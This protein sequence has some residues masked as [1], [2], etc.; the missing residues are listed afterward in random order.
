VDVEVLPVRLE[1]T[2]P[3][4]ACQGEG[5]IGAPG[6]PNPPEN[7]RAEIVPGDGPIAGQIILLTWD[8]NATDDICYTIEWT[9]PAPLAG[10]VRLDPS[11]CLCRPLSSKTF[12]RRGHILL[13]HQLWQ[14]AGR[15]SYS[16]EAC[17][18]CEAEPV[19]T[20]PTLPPHLSPETSPTPSPTPTPSPRPPSG[21][22]RGEGPTRAE[23]LPTTRRVPRDAFIGRRCVRGFIVRLQWKTTPTTSNAAIIGSG[24]G[25]LGVPQVEAPSVQ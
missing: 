7:L 10:A 17:V 2:P 11:A 12:L 16:N 15:S 8:D 19:W 25:R 24:C 6:A 20:T 9:G 21:T 23:A 14:R 3:P 1:A 22:C 18:E 13:S 4:P 5:P